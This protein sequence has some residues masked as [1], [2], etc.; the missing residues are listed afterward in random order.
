MK[1][2]LTH[3]QIWLSGIMFLLSFSAC[4]NEAPT[5]DPSE[6]YLGNFR[7]RE[8]CGQYIDEYTLVISR[9]GN[10]NLKIT[11]LYNTGAV[12][13]GY[14]DTYGD[15]K[16]HDIR[17]ETSNPWNCEYYAK[18]GEGQLSGN[19]LTI[20]FLYGLGGLAFS[21]CDDISF[22]CIVTGYR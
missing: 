12:G 7:V 2:F 6:R 17:V 10:N 20:T 18:K 14:V 1:S 22:R 16:L 3:G 4:S 13:F 8:E 9:T 11:N 19:E 5:V 15:L 21:A